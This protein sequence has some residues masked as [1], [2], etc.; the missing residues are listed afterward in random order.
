M[1]GRERFHMA[2]IQW[3]LITNAQSRSMDLEWGATKFTSS[4]KG[5]QL[6]LLRTCGGA[7]NF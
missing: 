5:F 6:P 2:Y 1:Y 3:G 7:L 4:T